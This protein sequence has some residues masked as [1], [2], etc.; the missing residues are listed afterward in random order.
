MPESFLASLPKGQA[1]LLID[2][3]LSANVPFFDSTSTVI[4]DFI[5]YEKPFREIHLALP[6]L[7]HG[8]I[9]LSEALEI[10]GGAAKEMK[11]IDDAAEAENESAA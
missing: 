8:D 3:Y 2:E 10:L 6:A 4:D 1:E 5:S 7:A 9:T 11:A